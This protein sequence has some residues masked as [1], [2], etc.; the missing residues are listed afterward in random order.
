MTLFVRPED[1]RHDGDPERVAI[2]LPGRGYTPA[3]PLLHYARAVLVHHGWT[4]QE[5]WWP[6][7]PDPE[8]TPRWVQE[9]AT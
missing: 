5:I 2:V 1:A 8:S 9:Q 3:G 4:V 7:L 6:E